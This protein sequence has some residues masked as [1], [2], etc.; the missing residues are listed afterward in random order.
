MGG[1]DKLCKVFWG[2]NIFSAP[3]MG[4][5]DSNSLVPLVRLRDLEQVTLVT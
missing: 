3:G 4:K 2:V 5:A 1:H